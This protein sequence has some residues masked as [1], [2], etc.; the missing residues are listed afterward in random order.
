MTSTSLVV[1][2]SRRATPPAALPA[3]SSAMKYLRFICLRLGDGQLDEGDGLGHRDVARA[4]VFL[5]GVIRRR[6]RTTR[7]CIRTGGRLREDQRLRRMMGDVARHV[8]VLLMD[9]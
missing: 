9:V 8:V 6:R 5:R 1:A 7:R 4:Q 3:T 2:A